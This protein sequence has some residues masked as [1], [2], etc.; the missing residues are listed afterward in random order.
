M[1]SYLPGEFLVNVVA[2]AAAHG[3]LSVLEWL[4]G[5]YRENC[6]WRRYEFVQAVLFNDQSVGEWLLHRVVMRDGDEVSKVLKLALS[7]KCVQL[8]YQKYHPDV[9][10]AFRDAL[11]Y[12]RWEV[13]RWFM[14]TVTDEE[15]LA[16]AHQYNEAFESPAR[17]GALD[18][19][20]ELHDRGLVRVSKRTIEIAAENGRLNVVKWLIEEKEVASIGRAFQR[21]AD[22]GHLDV[23][24]YLHAEREDSCRDSSLNAAASTGSLETVQWLRENTRAHCSVVAMDWAAIDGHLEMVQ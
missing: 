7:L 5:N 19:L 1:Q 16:N 3:P 23:L 4:W 11:L 14:E 17:F 24:K 2:E 15:Y 18:L 12:G 13:V 8:L 10:E 22:G 6:Y 9:A 20:K 21:A